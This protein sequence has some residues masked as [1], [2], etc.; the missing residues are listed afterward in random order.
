MVSFSLKRPTQGDFSFKMSQVLWEAREFSLSARTLFWTSFHFLTFFKFP[1]L[2]LFQ[3]SK[4]K[5][6]KV[7]KFPK[8]SGSARKWAQKQKQEWSF[9]VWK[10]F[11]FEAFPHATDSVAKLQE[12]KGKSSKKRLEFAAR[13]KFLR[14]VAG[15]V[16]ETPPKSK[17][18]HP[19]QPKTLWIQHVFLT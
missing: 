2:D 4:M 12:N 13:E 15:D 1:L 5:W 7:S 17:R 6:R 16:V 14:M 10:S 9:E 3:V 18:F 8:P 19:R 11:G